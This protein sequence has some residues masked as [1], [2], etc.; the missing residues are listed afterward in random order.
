MLADLML[1][2]L[3]PVAAKRFG[4]VRKAL[5]VTLAVFLLLLICGWLGR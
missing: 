2:I 4:L 5:W 1:N 3:G